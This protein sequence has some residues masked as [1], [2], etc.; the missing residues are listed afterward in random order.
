MGDSPST[1]LPSIATM[2]AYMVSRSDRAR[3]VGRGRSL[4]NG[5]F[6]RRVAGGSGQSNAGRPRHLH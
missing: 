1:S 2:G 4:D 3:L 6:R 5:R